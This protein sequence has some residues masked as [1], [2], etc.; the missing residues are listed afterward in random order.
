MS[1][2]LEECPT[3]I[4]GFDEVTGGGFYKGQLVLVAGNA[5]SGK[6]T[7]AAKF[8]YEGARSYGDP[9]LFISSGESR[10]EFY[11]YMKRLGMDFE[12]I[13]GR[14][15][16]RYVA[17]PTPTSTDFLMRLSKE[18]V[19]EA[20][21]LKARRV[22]VDSI[23]PFLTLSPPMEVRAV[24][25][26]ALKTMART[27]GTTMMLTVE[28]PQGE[29]RIGAEVEEFACDAL[30]RLT[31]TVP[32]AGA[33][34]RVMEVL[35][36][37]G[38]PLGRVVYDYEIG[39][40]FGIRVLPTGIVEELESRVCRYERLSTGI[41][42]LDKMLGGGLIRG[43]ITLVQ[44]PPGSG[45]TLIALSI[46]A[47]SAEDGVRTLYI[48]FEEPKQQL[49]ETLD[50]MGY[51]VKRFKDFLRLHSVS[52]RAVTA[53]GAYDVV[54]ALLSYG[55][56][57]ELLVVDG[58]TAMRREFG[59]EFVTVMR[60]LAFTAKKRGLSLVVTM[61]PQPTMLSTIADT[62]ISLRIREEDG[63]LRREVCVMKM[64]MSAPEPRYR[65]MRIVDSR[66]VIS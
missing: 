51:D 57:V 56:D 11:A 60:D 59:E 52:P 31:L 46:A 48:S 61:L 43:T 10:E 29:S 30:I 8:V 47:K 32:A 36:L 17:F 23:T 19:S 50:F 41:E 7:F 66:L 45:K 2:K 24:L 62:L 1:S 15:L 25:H 27:L 54:E 64:R 21:E 39:A 53:R 3:G 14:G 40:P 5:G 16:F 63:L 28:V 55:G 26:N 13:E 35:K 65:E 12:E 6:T 9:G 42:G 34:R 20:M 49:M 58:V 4:P 38:R 33:P 22:V 18:L 37:R 44:G